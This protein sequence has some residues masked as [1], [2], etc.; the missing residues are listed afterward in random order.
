MD[1]IGPDRQVQG[2][3]RLAGDGK[4]QGDGDG[5]HWGG[6]GARDPHEGRRG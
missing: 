2:L 1:G 3:V 5:L 4:G 6:G